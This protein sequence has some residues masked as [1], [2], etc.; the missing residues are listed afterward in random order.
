MISRL[1]EDI[2]SSD[3]DDFECGEVDFPNDFQELQSSLWYND[4]LA[5][6]YNAEAFGAVQ[7]VETT[8]AQLDGNSHSNSLS[9][10]LSPFNIKPEMVFSKYILALAIK[11]VILYLQI[12]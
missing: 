5:T 11:V 8:V 3:G 9:L 12:E 1:V 10:S 7:T 2:N 4:S 6:S